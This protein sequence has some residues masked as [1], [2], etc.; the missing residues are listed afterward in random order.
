MLECEYMN[1]LMG[2]KGLIKKRTHSEPRQEPSKT[3]EDEGLD[4]T[5]DVEEPPPLDS[6]AVA[7]KEDGDGAVDGNREGEH[8]EP[9]PENKLSD[10]KE[11]IMDVHVPI[12]R[13]RYTFIA[14][15]KSKTIVFGSKTQRRK[16]VV[17]TRQP[18]RQKNN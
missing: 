18:D 2:R 14:K 7:G 11:R 9:A 8:Q 16:E 3:A 15:I 12:K 17:A 10:L 4:E 1:I 6:N 13:Q 5:N